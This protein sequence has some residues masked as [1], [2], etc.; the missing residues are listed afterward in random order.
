[1]DADSD[2]EDLIEVFEASLEATGDLADCDIDPVDNFLEKL[3]RHQWSARHDRA[4]EE[5]EKKQF[6]ESAARAARASVGDVV[7]E[8][9][10]AMY[11]KEEI[12]QW[13]AAQDCSVADFQRRWI[14]QRGDIFFVFVAGRYLS[15]VQ[16]SELA[17]SLPRDLAPAPIEWDVWGKSGPRPKKV[18]ELLR[19]YCT[20]AR[21]L[22]A[23][24][25]I[26]ESYYDPD[27]QVFVEAVCRRRNISPVYHAKIDTWLRL[28]AGNE[29]EKFLD[30]IATVTMLERQNS[31]LYCCGDPNTGKTMLASGLARLWT[32]GSPTDLDGALSSFND[33]L[34]Q[35]P[36]IFGDEKIPQNFRGQRDSA[37][38]RQLIAVSQRKLKRKFMPICDLVGAIRLILAANNDMLLNFE[39]Q[40]SAWDQK[41]V[42]GRFLFIETPKAASD[43]LES[44]GG[45]RG[46]DGWV[47]KDMI[48]EHALW[49]KETRQVLHGSRF[50]VEVTRRHSVKCWRRKAN[51]RRWCSSGF[52]VTWISRS[53]WLR[54]SSSSE[55][56][57]Y[58]SI[59]RRWAD[60]WDSYI[61]SD[62]APSAALIGRTLSNLSSGA[63]QEDGV[64]YHELNVKLLLAWAKKNQVGDVSKLKAKIDGPVLKLVKAGA[65]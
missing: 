51:G 12:E 52:A 65:K 46:T 13:A 33:S 31:A 28:F 59:A 25:T 41:A 55:T 10:S 62:R 60:S 38:L 24:M 56:D 57:G 7:D 17:I 53:R 47:D 63:A 37:E 27:D 23:D 3:A 32:K 14:I 34:I 26:T 44:L 9:V 5:E 35:C 16:R 29:A 22:R 18:D 43:Y 15:P 61:K 30:W 42:A 1:M 19:D 50:L 36:L 8:A 64:R 4:I 48:A 54:R 2:P 20:V 49:L 58:S 21:N 40:L 39:E 45:R 6:L 11:S